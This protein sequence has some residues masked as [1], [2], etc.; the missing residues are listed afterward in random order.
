MRTAPNCRRSI[1]VS[2]LTGEARRPM[3]RSLCLRALAAFIAGWGLLAIL[4][5]I[6]TAQGPGPTLTLRA[7]ARL[8]YVDVVVRDSAGRIVHGLKESDFHLSEDKQGQKILFFE[9]H[10]SP[11]GAP[12]MPVA[13][14]AVGA[15]PNVL[16]EVKDD[17]LNLVLFDFLNADESDQ[18]T[19]ASA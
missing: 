18:S 2:T 6:A 12:T 3:L 5:A 1:A 13:P 8:V 10:A 17:T 9:E 14:T 7:T 16:P 19:P 4:P 15:V 11:G